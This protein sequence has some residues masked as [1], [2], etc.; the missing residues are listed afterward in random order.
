MKTYYIKC[1]GCQQNKNDAEI[2]AGIME[3]LGYSPVETPEE[4]SV[5]LVNTCTVRWAAEN[6][7]LGYIGKLKGII[8]RDSHLTPHISR[9]VGICGCLAQQEKDGL[10]K[11]YP[12]VDFVLGPGSLHELASMITS[13]ACRTGRHLAS[14]ISHLGPFIETCDPSL[15][16]L[17]QKRKPSTVAY[18]SIM[19]GCDNFC[20]FCIVP[21][22]RG[23]EV[24]RP[25]EDILTEIEGLDKSVFK[26]VVLLGQNVNSYG[27]GYEVKGKGEGNDP[28]TSYPLPY[29]CNLAQLLREV[30]AIKGIDRIKFLT[31]HPRDMSDEIIQAVKEL[32]KVCEYFHLPLQSGDDEVLK[33]MNRGYTLHYYSDLVDKIRKAIPDAA[34]TSDVIVGF[35]GETDKQLKNTLKAIK[36]VGFDTVNT[37][38]YSDRPGTAASKMEGKIPEEVKGLRLKEV[39][40]VVEATALKKNQQLVGKTV[41]ILVDS[42]NTGRTRGNKIVKFKGDKAL[43]GKLVNVAITKA[44]SFIMEGETI[45]NSR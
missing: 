27:K 42:P 6:K 32:P 14:P 7:A 41:E 3:S 43:V 22:V 11:K 30:N 35:P 20:S 19:Y 36:D 10:L 9:L 37:L 8:D 29:T 26:E 25:K 5:V 44:K 24:S 39:M 18:V 34:I 17:P 28:H 13:P 40:G 33:A 15:R 16:N 45:P 2:L 31:S 1:Y 23:R 4:A 21:Y 12:F 38:S